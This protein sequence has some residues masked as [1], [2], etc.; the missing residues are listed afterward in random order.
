MLWPGD[1]TSDEALADRYLLLACFTARPGGRAAAGTLRSPTGEEQEGTGTLKFVTPA[2][3]R[4]MRS[5]R[6]RYIRLQYTHPKNRELRAKALP[7]SIT[8]SSAGALTRYERREVD[9]VVLWGCCFVGFGFFFLLCVVCHVAVV[10]GLHLIVTR[11]HVYWRGL[12]FRVFKR[13]GER[14][15]DPLPSDEA[16]AAAPL[17]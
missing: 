1:D 12:P 11:L 16:A 9:C 10:L 13:L 8:M 15:D 6:P 5:V 7:A 17:L 4:E 14:P 3:I 2:A